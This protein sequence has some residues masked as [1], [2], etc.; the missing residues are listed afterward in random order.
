MREQ[1]RRYWSERRHN[2]YREH[3]GRDL[4]TYETC[5]RVVLDDGLFF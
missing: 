1:Y 3:R 2:W 4:G 5:A